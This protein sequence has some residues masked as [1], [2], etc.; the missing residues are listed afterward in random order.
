MV[1]SAG[2][3]LARQALSVGGLR[4]LRAEILCDRA[5]RGLGAR[6]A[7]GVGGTLA[8]AHQVR[9]TAARGGAV[10]ALAVGG[11]GARSCLVLLCKAAVAGRALAVGGQRAL[12]I[13]VE[14]CGARARARQAHGRGGARASASQVK[15]TGAGGCAVGA[16]VARD[17]GLVAASGA[18][19][20][21]GVASASTGALQLLTHRAGGGASSALAVG[22]K[23]GS[24]AL[25]AARVAHSQKGALDVLSA[26]TSSSLVLSGE[27]ARATR[28]AT[29]RSNIAIGASGASGRAGAIGEEKL[30]AITLDAVGEVGPRA[31]GTAG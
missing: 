27:I 26:T 16:S 31:L 25:V 7:D 15:A 12:T 11:G 6:R 28:K 8:G 10:G 24:H 23:R 21:R 30:G 19:R 22:E 9:A 4:A 3:F 2:A 5:R 1:L 20:A 18:R 17:I 13:Q 29:A 14:R